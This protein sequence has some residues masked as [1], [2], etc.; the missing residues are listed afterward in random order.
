MVVALGIV[1]SQWFDLPH[2]GVKLGGRAIALQL[3]APAMPALARAEWLRLGEIGLGDGHDPLCRK[4]R[5]DPQFCHQ[6]RRC[7][8]AE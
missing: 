3:N 7:D 6:A 5:L 1:A 2:Y 4:L 8:L